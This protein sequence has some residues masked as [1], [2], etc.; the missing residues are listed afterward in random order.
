MNIS[1][2]DGVIGSNSIFKL[3]LSSDS[4]LDHR[5]DSYFHKGEY[6][7]VQF[8]SERTF[9]VF[10]DKNSTLGVERF[11]FETRNDEEA[12]NLKEVLS[13]GHFSKVMIDQIFK[14]TMT[15]ESF[16]VNSISGASAEINIVVS[17]GVSVLPEAI[18]DR[19]IL[20]VN[21]SKYFAYGTIPGE[22]GAFYLLN[23]SGALKVQDRARYECGRCGDD[24]ANDIVHAVITDEPVELKKIPM[25]KREFLNT[26]LR[27]TSAYQGAK[28][29]TKDIVSLR[30]DPNFDAYLKAW[31]VYSEE[32]KALK[33]EQ[34]TNAGA[35]IPTKYQ[36]L[37]IGLYRLFVDDQKRLEN[38]VTWLKKY[39]SFGSF[40]KISCQIGRKNVYAFAS[41]SGSNLANCSFDL[42]IDGELPRGFD[43]TRCAVE[44]ND[45]PFTTSDAR[46]QTAFMDIANDNCG[47]PNFN[48]LISGKKPLPASGTQRSETLLDPE[49]L[50]KAFG[51]H[52]PTEN[53]LAAIK[54][55][56][57]T[58][59]FAIIQGPPG[60]GKT[61]VI[62]AIFMSLKANSE[63]KK[64]EFGQNL[65]TAY[66]RDATRNLSKSIYQAFGLPS[67]AY[68]GRRAGESDDISD[69]LEW[70]QK[71]AEQVEE[72]N[73]GIDKVFS[74]YEKVKTFEL[75]RSGFD[76]KRS[77][78]CVDFTFLSNL[79]DKCG[80]VF[81]FN[82]RSDLQSLKEE[83]DVKA[84]S[85]RETRDLNVPLCRAL[86]R[87]LPIK[88][89]GF[90]DGG[91]QAVEPI[92]AELRDMGSLGEHLGK[93]EK[94]YHAGTI[95]F[96]VVEEE[97]DSALVSIRNAKDLTIPVAFNMEI[98][99]ILKTV[100]LSLVQASMSDKEKI[101]S[102]Y[103]YCLKYQP[104]E[105]ASSLEQFCETIAA[106]HQ[107]ADSTE[108]RLK[109]GNVS[110]EN[111]I[112]DEAA[113]SCPADLLIPMTKAKKRI[114]LVGDQNQLPQ[115][116]SDEIYERMDDK[117]TGSTDKSIIKETMF[118]YLIQS[119]K[120]LTEIDHI[121]RVA[122]LD[123]QFRMPKELG[124]F[125]GWEFY[126]EDDP[127]TVSKN[128]SSLV[129]GD[130]PL[131]FASENPESFNHSLPD[132]KNVCMAFYGIP[133]GLGHE[134]SIGTSYKRPIEAQRIALLLKDYLSSE[135][136]KNLTYAITTFYAAQIKEIMTCLADPKIGIA[137]EGP[138]GV[139]VIK[140]QYAMNKI[141][142]GTVDSCQG[143]QWDVV[144]LSM[145]RSSKETQ[146]PNPR[147]VY[148]FLM[149]R[150]R[151]CIALSRAQKCCI[152]VGNP[153]TLLKADAM[154]SVQP[155]VDFYY[156][157]NNA[158]KEGNHAKYFT[159]I[160]SK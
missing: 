65:T 46:R 98:D 108:L 111:V 96:K 155:L 145:V 31:A 80:G 119:A 43:W 28:A 6:I 134:I 62:T 157:C 11:V 151:L 89:T 45:I 92:L 18:A 32:E 153:D 110:Y 131:H 61:T 49:V 81:S 33:T 10:A 34:I 149:S 25:N 13:T 48:A 114:I 50:E 137:E 106:T 1:Q 93:I 87:E 159:K 76:P 74:S 19:Y 47:I 38:F 88:S 118:E 122:R 58:P 59:D 156:V 126:S 133:S 147:R 139:Y 132:L 85:L 22:E 105:I 115:L 86:L 3:T 73:P 128:I 150:N 116:I 35:L 41:L 102:D 101:I 154:E 127:K 79:L 123:D 146:W 117:I 97:I 23:S 144:L 129:L 9:L 40:V 57:S 51:G 7:N 8:R 4:T 138:D 53:Q 113:R 63:T 103:L 17:N 130:S 42:K 37:E 30:D 141:H 54:M 124:N 148:G 83:A 60:T 75:L 94:L 27:F 68:L 5:L 72:A 91:L 152:V 12:A 140:P 109:K 112:A 44:L 78:Y 70:S 160:L 71:A 21:G 56:L 104:Y 143:L 15:I 95:D 100:D 84:H 14:D 69:V 107:I 39:D 158:E 82:Q 29:A 16:T 99:Q 90:N 120:K 136:G 121:T 26:P 77:D 135:G 64:I 125:I 142:V 66:Q 36:N 67:R 24:V 20:D 52:K 2:L 55:A